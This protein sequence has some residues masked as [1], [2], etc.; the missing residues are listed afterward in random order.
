MDRNVG[1]LDRVGRSVVALALLGIGY[2]N[3]NSTPGTLAFVA[4]SDLFATAVIGR[5]PVNALVGIDTCDGE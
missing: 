1:G 4:G 3:R 5:C 2:R